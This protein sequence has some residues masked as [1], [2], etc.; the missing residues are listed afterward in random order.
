MSHE[1]LSGAF[2]FFLT[3]VQSL[4]CHE[5]KDSPFEDAVLVPVQRGF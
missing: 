4:S 2:L 1:N 3:D 5:D